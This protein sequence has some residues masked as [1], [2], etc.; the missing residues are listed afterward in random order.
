VAGT[1]PPSQDSRS[2]VSRGAIR[3]SPEAALA[4][5]LVVAREAAGITQHRLAAAALVSR[6]TVAQ[7]ETGSSDPRLSTIVDLARALDI[8]PY[9]LLVGPEEV[10]ALI[11][12]PSALVERPLHVPSADLDRMH[13]LVQSGMLKDRIRAARI[14][15]AVAHDAG[16][17]SHAAVVSAAIFSA[18]QPDGGTAVGTALGDLTA[19]IQVRRSISS[20]P[21]Q[22]A[23]SHPSCAAA[24]D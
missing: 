17:P 5:N 18:I 4:K 22:A 15:A 12:M 24:V 14:G 23:G 21:S 10:E 2:G 13:R 9:F 11:A 6:A 8:P 7:I 20:F 16:R 1:N 19:S 3:E